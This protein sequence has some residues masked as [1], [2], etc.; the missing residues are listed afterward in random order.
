MKTYTW[1]LY[2]HEHVHEC[3]CVH[4]R[5]WICPCMEICACGCVCSCGR[6]TCTPTRRW[7]GLLRVHRHTRTCGE[8]AEPGGRG[9][10]GEL[11]AYGRLRLVQS[12]GGVHV[13]PERPCW[14]QWARSPGFRP[15]PLLLRLPPVRP[16]PRPQ[17]RPLLP[18]PWHQSPRRRRSQSPLQA[19]GR[20]DEETE[21]PQAR[22]K[23][24]PSPLAPA[25]PPR[26]EPPIPSAPC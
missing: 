22:D 4:T 25:P 9:A 1:P 7:E 20:G 18:V 19:G 12:W 11:S 17:E 24:S 23:G 13:L 26:R 2:I 10:G 16:L 6:P 3:V 21:S 5:G 8:P 15:P 14:K